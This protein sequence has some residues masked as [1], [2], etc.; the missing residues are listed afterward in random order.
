M[1]TYT[2][3]YPQYIDSALRRIE[4]GVHRRI[5]RRRHRALAVVA[6]AVVLVSGTSVAAA[7]FWPAAQGSAYIECFLSGDKSSNVSGG[8]G[9]DMRDPVGLCIDV[10]DYRATVTSPTISWKNTPRTDLMACKLADGVAGVFPVDPN[11]CS[12]VDLTPWTSADA[13][14]ATQIQAKYNQWQHDKFGL[15]IPETGMTEHQVPSP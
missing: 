10:M 11:G 13:D 2:E 3:P 7:Q 1:N 15:P 4:D 8:V 9:F 14:Q 6:G 5:T 12:A